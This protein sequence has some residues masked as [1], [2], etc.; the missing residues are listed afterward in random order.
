MLSMLAAKAPDRAAAQFFS[1]AAS[2]VLSDEIKLHTDLLTSWG[3][4]L[5]DVEDATMQ[6]AGVMYTRYLEAVV[7]NQPF[8]EGAAT[9]STVSFDD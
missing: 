9:I 1:T 3:L 2:K 7:S 4:A 8:Y 6:P 5:K